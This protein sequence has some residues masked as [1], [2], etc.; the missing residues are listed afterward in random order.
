MNDFITTYRNE[1]LD[2]LIDFFMEKDID[3]SHADSAA[4]ASYRYTNDME[5]GTFTVERL[6]SG[7]DTM[8]EFMSTVEDQAGIKEFQVF[9]EST[10]LMEGLHYLLNTGWEIAAPI[11]IKAPWGMM[12]GLKLQKK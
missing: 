2:N 7:F 3:P 1:Y 4:I 6:P 5:Q 10:G 8:G 11:E 12:R 9:D